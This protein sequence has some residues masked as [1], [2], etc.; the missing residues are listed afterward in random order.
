MSVPC[1]AP[2]RTLPATPAP[3]IRVLCRRCA[4]PRDC[5]AAPIPSPLGRLFGSGWVPI[6]GACE[7]GSRE[8]FPAD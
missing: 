2:G 5:A 6:A 1:D 4:A 7:C 3:T 8:I